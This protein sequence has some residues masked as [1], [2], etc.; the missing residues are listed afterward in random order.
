M[1]HKHDETCACNKA[2]AWVAEE[3]GKYIQA[4]M[5]KG[6][7]PSEG[8]VEAKVHFLGLAHMMIAF[9]DDVR[10]TSASGPNPTTATDP[11][12]DKSLH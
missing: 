12:I 4:C 5:T 2:I 11:A 9:V 6:A 7:T 8:F 3:F 10:M 1:S